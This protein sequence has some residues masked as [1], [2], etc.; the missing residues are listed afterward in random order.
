MLSTAMGKSRLSG[1][2]FKEVFITSLTASGTGTIVGTLLTLVIKS[3]MAN[4]QSVVMD[5]DI[6]PL[7]IV[8]FFI[9]MTVVFTGTVLF[10]L[11]N[12]R[13]MKIAEQ[14]KYE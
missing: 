7:A 2:L 11:N 10:P 9:A 4:A 1:I 13:K 8:L 6:N 5:V 14:I 3:A 12:L